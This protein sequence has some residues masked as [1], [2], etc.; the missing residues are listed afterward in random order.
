DAEFVTLSAVS[1]G[2]PRI[3]EAVAE[4]ERMRNEQRRRTVLF[5]DEIHRWAKNVQEQALPH[6]ES[7]LFLLLG[8]TTENPS[9]ELRAALLSRCRVFQLQALTHDDLR[10]ALT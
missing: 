5:V 6:V 4:A 1:D 9:F 7:G 10:Q 8:A 2:I 3:R